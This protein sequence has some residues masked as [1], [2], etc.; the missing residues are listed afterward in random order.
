MTGNA[1]AIQPEVLR[2]ASTELDQVGN[3][4]RE[5][6]NSLEQEVLTGVGEPW[7]NDNIGKLIGQ[8]YKEV[9]HWAFDILRELLNELLK[10]GVDLKKMAE[11]YERLEQDLSDGFQKFLDNLGLR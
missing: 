4:L 7:G 9:V 8:A 2:K 11:R 6:L 1:I 3:K 5:L 10:S